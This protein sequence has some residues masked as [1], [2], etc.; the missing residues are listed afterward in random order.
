MLNAHDKNWQYIDC[1]W[2]RRW[3]KP[4]ISAFVVAYHLKLTHEK[5]FMNKAWLWG[6]YWT[7]KNLSRVFLVSQLLDQASLWTWH[8]IFL[9]ILVPLNNWMKI[10]LKTCFSLSEFVKSVCTFPA[11]CLCNVQL[12][13]CVSRARQYLSQIRSQI[14]D[15]VGALTFLSCSWCCFSAP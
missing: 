3:R 1:M 5:M 13:P 7:E 12:S 2:R 10:L 11:P 6:K 4:F 15:R 8:N 14:C 9:V